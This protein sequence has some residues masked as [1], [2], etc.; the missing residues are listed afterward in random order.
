MLWRFTVVSPA[1]SASV[2]AD[3][4]RACKNQRVL[5]ALRKTATVILSQLY[6]Q[7]EVFAED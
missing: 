4:W 7:P 2:V 3:S 1:L 6:P 5:V